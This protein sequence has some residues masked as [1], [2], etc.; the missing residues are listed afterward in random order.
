MVLRSWQARPLALYTLLYTSRACVDWIERP[1]HAAG[2][3]RNEAAARPSE[4]AAFV[5][6]A[7]AM[8]V[9]GSGSKIEIILGAGRGAGTIDYVCETLDGEEGQTG[10]TKTTL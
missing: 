8:I 3:R 2:V 6:R 5:M 7:A 1:L 4:G 10:I 9:A